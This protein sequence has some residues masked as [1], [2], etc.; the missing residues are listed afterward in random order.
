MKQLSERSLA[1]RLKRAH[2]ILLL[3]HQNPDGDTLGS[4]YGLAYALPHACVTI[5]NGD[6][7]AENIAFLCDQDLPLHRY[8]EIAGKHFD[9]IVSIDVADPKLLG[10]AFAQ[11]GLQVDYKI[12]HHAMGK[13]FAPSGLVDPTAAAC[14]EIIYRIIKRLGRVSKKSANALYAAISS[15]TG[16][17]RYENT[18]KTTHRIVADLIEAGCDHAQINHNLYESH[19]QKEIA[20]MRYCWENLQF[21]CDGKIAVLTITNAQKEQNGFEDSDLAILN[22]LPRTVAGVELSVVLKQSTNHPENYRASLR[23]GTRVRANEICAKFGG[24]GH[25]RAAGATIS[26]PSP[27]AA[28]DLLLQAAEEFFQ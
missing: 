28:R 7:V 13:E 4:A 3:T 5:V 21:F 12:D 19:S 1:R 23:S 10:D 27:E 8:E 2:S 15:D 6:K 20:V 25:L 26:A 18:T 16:G 9:L 22:S 17:F 24:G 14:G 11:S